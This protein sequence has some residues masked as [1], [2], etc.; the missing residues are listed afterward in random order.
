[1]GG[2]QPNTN[3]QIAIARFGIFSYPS[4]FINKFIVF[5]S[6]WHVGKTPLGSDFGMTP[7]FDANCMQ[8]YTAFLEVVYR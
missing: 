8:P 1:M 2:P 7:G 3:G 5:F 6:S 4:S